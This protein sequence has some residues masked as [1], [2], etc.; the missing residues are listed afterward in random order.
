MTP[1]ICCESFSEGCQFTVVAGVSIVNRKSSCQFENTP[2]VQLIPSHFIENTNL[3]TS[4]KELSLLLDILNLKF[5][6]TTLMVG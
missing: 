2:L 4:L 6:N 1:E 5:R 3:T